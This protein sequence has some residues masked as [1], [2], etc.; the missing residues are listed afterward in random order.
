V[1]HKR[2][3][4]PFVLLLILV[5]LAVFLWR[6]HTGPG[7]K[8]E[9]L[10]A[11]AVQRVGPEGIYPDAARTPGFAN[12]VITQDNIVDTICNPDWSTKEI[13]PPSSYTSRLKR[14]QM[15]EWSLP[16]RTSDYEED[17]L[18]SLELG[19]NPT[20]PRNLWP[21][22]YRPKPGAKEKDVVENYLHRQVCSGAM[23]L[24][25]AQNA[26]ATDWYKVYLEIRQ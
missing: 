19:G 10:P 3:R 25:A 8:P 2:S 12:P 5:L 21:E 15:Q 22:P 24:Q 23:T 13:R 18:I 16:G 6:W 7:S 20:D 11:A 26:I 4:F 17:H 1:R 9:P 14:E